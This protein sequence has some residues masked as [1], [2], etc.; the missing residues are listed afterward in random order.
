MV[1][2][3][4][5]GKFSSDFVRAVMVTYPHGTQSLISPQAELA[6]PWMNT[7]LRIVDQIIRQ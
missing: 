7:L 1:G 3:A 6:A 2:S 4:A 5:I